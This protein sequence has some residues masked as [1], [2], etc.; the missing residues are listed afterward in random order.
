MADDYLA[1]QRTKTL[2]DDS[3]V[4]EAELHATHENIR[5]SWEELQECKRR[6][7]AAK[8]SASIKVDLEFK[9]ELDQL[10]ADYALVMTLSR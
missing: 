5:E 2:D 9:D 7:A 4:S 6:I 3:T 1:N 8:N 10:M